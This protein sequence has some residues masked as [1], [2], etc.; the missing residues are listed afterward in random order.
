MSASAVGSV[1]FSANEDGA[2]TAAPSALATNE[3][4]PA[5][6]QLGRHEW[7][8]AIHADEVDPGEQEWRTLADHKGDLHQIGL[9]V[10]AH[11]IVDFGVRKPLFRI[12]VAQSND[13]TLK[14]QWIERVLA[15]GRNKREPSQ[16]V[17][18]PDQSASLSESD[19]AAQLFFVQ[20]LLADE[21]E[22][23]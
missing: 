17:S 16:C 22:I 8:S 20:R 7:W 23:D 12:V 1:S 21:P 11:G 10:V 2:A 3:P 18:E 6:L 19:G 15:H 9:G 14:N 4:L 5:G 13:V